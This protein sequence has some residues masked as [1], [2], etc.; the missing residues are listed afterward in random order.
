M[1]RALTH[2]RAGGGESGCVWLGGEGERRGWGGGGGGGGGWDGDRGKDG[3]R[4]RI[5][6]RRQKCTLYKVHEFLSV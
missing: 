4:M 2:G 6:C 1:A 3:A 5:A